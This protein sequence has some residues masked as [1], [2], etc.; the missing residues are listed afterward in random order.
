MVKLKI[1]SENGF[2]ESKKYYS[3]IL[4]DPN[5][6]SS[7][8]VGEYVHLFVQALCALGFDKESIEKYIEIEEKYEDVNE[9]CGEYRSDIKKFYGVDVIEDTGGSRDSA[10]RLGINIKD[11]PHDGNPQE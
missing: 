8:P 4:K 3:A 7:S 2:D 11:K 10:E 6:Y 5:M 9:Y 1:Q